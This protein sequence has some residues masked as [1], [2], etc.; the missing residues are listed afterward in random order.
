MKINGY[1]RMFR[2]LKLIDNPT[3]SLLSIFIEMTTEEE[4]QNARSFKLE[5]NLRYLEY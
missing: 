1:N 2:K 4:Y 5:V 3:I